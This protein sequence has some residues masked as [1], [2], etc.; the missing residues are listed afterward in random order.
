MDLKREFD[1]GVD[2][3]VSLLLL[4]VKNMLFLKSKSIPLNILAVTQPVAL[5]DMFE[6]VQLV[7]AKA[8]VVHSK[9]SRCPVASCGEHHVDHDLGHIELLSSWECCLFGSTLG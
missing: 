6:G 3:V 1:K 9:V 8:Q 4:P 7:V 5:P 2:S